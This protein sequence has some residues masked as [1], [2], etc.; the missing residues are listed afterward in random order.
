MSINIFI[1]SY[2]LE[3]LID[4]RYFNFSKE[5]VDFIAN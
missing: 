5:R 3:V 2:A 1:S 4:A